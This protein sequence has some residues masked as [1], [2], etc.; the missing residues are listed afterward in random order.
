MQAIT[1]RAAKQ[2]TTFPRLLCMPLETWDQFLGWCQQKWYKTVASQI[3]KEVSEPSWPSPYLSMNKI[4]GGI[5]GSRGRQSHMIGAFV[6]KCG[7]LSANQ[8]QPMWILCEGRRNL[9]FINLLR[10]WTHSLE[11]LASSSV[12][13]RSTTKWNWDRYSL[14]NYVS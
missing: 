6:V 1:R 7:K 3:D 5:H 2:W 4:Q 13:K 14:V 9:Y 12:T 10:F 11:Q 8:E